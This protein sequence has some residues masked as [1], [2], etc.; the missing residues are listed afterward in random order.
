[1]TKSTKTQ[2]PPRA[3]KAK[4]QSATGKTLPQAAQGTGLP[5]RE[6]KGKIASLV[7]LLRR[8]EGADI[9][10]MMEAT[11]W[12]AHSVRGALSG[13]IKKGLG[14]T[15]VSEKIDAERRYRIAPEANA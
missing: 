7:V 4:A 11:G 15:V 12:Q 14:L 10:A 8:E 1:M 5:A 3:S 9:K 6:P 2:S 13:A